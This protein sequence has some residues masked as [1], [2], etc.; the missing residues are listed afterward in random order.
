MN[1]VFYNKCEKIKNVIKFRFCLKNTENLELTLYSQRADRK[2][3]L[4]KTGSQP[5]YL[6]PNNT[7]IL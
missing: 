5:W 1:F 6:I 4:F 7:L 3:D 2:V